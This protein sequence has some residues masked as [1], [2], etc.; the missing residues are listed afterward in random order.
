VPDQLFTYYIENPLV[1][2]S[3]NTGS[4][5]EMVIKLD[6]EIWEIGKDGTKRGLGKGVGRGR[7]MGAT[8]FCGPCVCLDIFLL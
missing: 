7:S 1:I 8:E 6:I 4:L 2:I 5:G 3:I